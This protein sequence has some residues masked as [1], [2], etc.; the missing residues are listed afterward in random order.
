[1]IIH[2]EGLDLAGKSTLTRRFIANAPGQWLTRRNRLTEENPV[3]DLAEHYRLNGGLHTE[4]LGE[5][6]LTALLVD[7]ETWR[8]P[9]GNIVQDSTILLRSHAFYAARGS[10]RLADRF[11]E[12]M[13]THPKFD[14]SFVCTCSREVRLERLGKRR[15]ENLGPE[16]FLIVSD[17]GLFA[18]TERI[19]I[20]TATRHFGA[21]TI[22]TDHLRSDDDV[23]WLLE[24]L[25][26]LDHLAGE[27]RPRDG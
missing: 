25:P 11:E 17:P 5:L 16:D 18:E 9:A 6:Y 21:E 2:F 22:E 1:M 15:K 23:A 10:R 19:L 12:L 26:E 8:R 7:L 14:R 24:R 27:S 3:H 20:E 4:T 13:E